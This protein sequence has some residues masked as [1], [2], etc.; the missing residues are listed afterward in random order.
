MHARTISAILLGI[1]T[2]TITTVASAHRPEIVGSTAPA[3][4]ART[5][6]E[7]AE[8]D[9][10]GAAHAAEH[11]RARAEMRIEA[12]LPLR[13]RLAI[14]RRERSAYRRVRLASAQADGSWDA[15]FR[16]PSFALHAAL[17]PTGKVLLFGFTRDPDR[18]GYGGGNTAQAWLWNPAAGIGRAA[19]ENVDPPL[20][21]NNGTGERPA[22]LYCSGFAFAGNGTLVLIGGNRN[23]GNEEGGRWVFTFDPFA[24]QWHEQQST[25][26]G[27]WYPTVV[28]RPD[29]R[30]VTMAGWT[31]A[32][33]D[34]YNTDFEVFPALSTPV[35]AATPE[36]RAAAGLPIGRIALLDRQTDLYPHLRLLRGGRLS[37]VGPAG[38]DSAITSG[39]L[40][41]PASGWVDLDPLPVTDAGNNNR[42]GGNAVLVPGGPDGPD[43]V[44]LIGGFAL[45]LPTNPKPAAAR[46][47]EI[48]PA[49]TTPRWQ[50]HSTLNAGRDQANTVLLPNGSMA[51]IGGS[52][53]YLATPN[54][55]DEVGRRNAG[56]TPEERTT[57]LRPELYDPASGSWRLGPPQTYPRT[58]H[59]VALMLP[60]G[61]ILSTGDEIHEQRA[62]ANAPFWIGT[63]EV[64]RPAYLFAGARPVLE[65]APPQIPYDAAFPAQTP[66]VASVDR[67]VLMAPS[68]TTHG[69]DST[70][71][72]VEL[73][74]VGR[75]GDALTLRAPHDGA[76]A[77]PGY[78]ML[79]LLRNGVP[80]VAKFVR[81]GA[82]GVEPSQIVAQFAPW[83]S[84]PVATATGSPTAPPAAASPAPGRPLGLTARVR[85]RTVTLSWRAVA[86][87][88]SYTVLRDGHAVATVRAATSRLTG[89][90]PDR[91]YLLTVVSRDATGAISPPSPVLAVRM[92]SR[93]T[94]ATLHR[95]RHGFVVLARSSRPVTL[96]LV[97]RLG[98]R[99]TGRPVR[100]RATT[101]GARVLVP[102]PRNARRASVAAPWLA[103]S[104]WDVAVP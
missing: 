90:Q 63:A 35:P 14:A 19:Y 91:G 25:R 102:C 30:V 22:P 53:A 86:A 87:A 89:L 103:R 13:T 51:V 16:T 82:A 39:A 10:L 88:S 84:A 21:D 75:T 37:L 61:S 78:Y 9:S 11:R 8:I 67:A 36:G 2:L 31:E 99:S 33:S 48:A 24:E 23:L 96:N 93:L 32:G 94:I 46:V 44:A 66:D 65:A 15:P 92:L 49:D 104:R 5:A 62:T 55:D 60:D 45:G 79:F 4:A 34:S 68:A 74:I 98:G 29:G 41:D 57:M 100:V 52:P 42:N 72:H 77:P 12:A 81:L 50:T 95:N 17:L 97:A 76:V 27:R 1:G 40:L 18:F 71:R 38:D 64:Y 69:E 26:Q 20:V 83:R 80:S 56:S 73:R 54:A 6:A 47:D 7:R 28:E 85:S 58:Y 70:Q 43:T 59:S 3:P 101:A